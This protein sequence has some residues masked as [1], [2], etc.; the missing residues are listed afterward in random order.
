MNVFSA[1]QADTAL[2]RRCG[3]AQRHKASDTAFTG[4]TGGNRSS[5]VGKD[6]HEG[7]GAVGYWSAP[8]EKRRGPRHK[9]RLPL[10]LSIF[11]RPGVQEAWLI[12]CSQEGVC[13]E[14]AQ[15]LLPGTS[16]HLRVVANVSM[17]EPFG[18][19]TPV[20]PGLRT[21]ALGEVKWCEALS[22]GR[23]A[24]YRIGIRYYPYY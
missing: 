7:G 23:S 11:N 2:L 9:Q 21:T 17:D 3:S 5:L 1:F 4:E 8:A 12:N 24:R 13:V 20:F 19:E 14:T 10:A 15:P 18:E 16:I 22:P 6:S